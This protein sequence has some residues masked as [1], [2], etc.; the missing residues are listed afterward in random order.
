[1]VQPRQSLTAPKS[2][3]KASTALVMTLALAAVSMVGLGI[4]FKVGAA[5]EE[6]Q[7]KISKELE[8][9]IGQLNM[10]A[11]VFRQQ[12]KMNEAIGCMKQAVELLEQDKSTDRLP[13]AS[14][15]IGLSDMYRS[16]GKTNLGEPEVK[17]A[18]EIILKDHQEEN[19]LTCAILHREGLYKYIQKDYLAAE[20]YF[21]QSLTC[22]SSTIS[23][24][25]A[26][27]SD[28]LLWLAHVYLAPGMNNPEKAL[29]CLRQV[30]EVSNAVERPS[31]MMA[32]QK[33]Q[34]MAYLALKRYAEAEEKL[35]ASQQLTER[36]FTDPNHP[37]R[38]HIK[39]LIEQVR[40]AKS[41]K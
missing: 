27:T 3:F 41:A 28:D 29:R 5:P 16:T 9:K 14:A 6:R 10:Q 21:Q 23:S 1:M 19:A 36:L 40:A 2:H 25:S 8:M 38:V 31:H 24:L 30:E 37:Q 32:V 22:S 15:Y 4:F 17:R 13:L 26:E 7:E 39:K 20:E 18:K 12:N 11:Q 33:L 35:V 34:G